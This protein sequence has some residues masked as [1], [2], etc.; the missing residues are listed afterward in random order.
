MQL[1]AYAGIFFGGL[2]IVAF[3]WP[4]IDAICNWGNKRPEKPNYPQAGNPKRKN[5]K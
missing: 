3:I 5:K 2:L 4:I 1:L